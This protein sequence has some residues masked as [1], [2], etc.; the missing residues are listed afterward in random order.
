MVITST[1]RDEKP[2]ARGLHKNISNPQGPTGK[3]EIFLIAYTMRINR[4][5]VV[6]IFWGETNGTKYVHN[7]EAYRV[8]V[9]F[10]S[11][12]TEFVKLGF[13]KGLELISGSLVQ[14]QRSYKSPHTMS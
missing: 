6:I 9:H 13:V 2:S 14:Q 11:K 5:T 4:S 7:T 3:V 1:P 12:G 8:G 10:R